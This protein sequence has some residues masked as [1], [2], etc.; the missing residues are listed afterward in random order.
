MDTGLRGRRAL[1]TG[2]GS[3][4]GRAIAL[5]LAAEG[6]DVAICGRRE[7]SDV[8]A[9]LRRQ[10][11]EAIGLQADV[12]IEAEVVRVV[13]RAA[14]ALGGL[15]L[16]VNVAAG[17]W[18][19]PITRVSAAS[20]ERTM[21]TNVAACVWG[22]REVARRFI[23]QGHGTIL[24]IGSTALV[25]AQPMETAYRASKAAL[26]AHIEVAAVELAPHRI[27][28][29]LLTPGAV[30]TDFVAD[31][32]ADQRAA[33]MAQVPMRREAQPDEIAPAAVFLLSDRLAGYITGADLLVDGG[34]HLRPIFGGTDQALAA[35]VQPARPAPAPEGS[36]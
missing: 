5:A 14:E 34:L 30:D 11:V 15:D 36:T 23:G 4:I 21:A 2:G 27:R 10:G 12:S 6:V 32:S 25:S 35:L 20:W 18:H 7:R 17:T 24:A 19:E 8:V 33:A 28:V 29:N 16:Y 22:C 1:I 9:A 3:G 26:K 31:A 13:D